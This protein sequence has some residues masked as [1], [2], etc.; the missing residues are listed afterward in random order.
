MPLATIDCTKM[1]H[2][3]PVS[4]YHIRPLHD[5]DSGHARGDDNTY[6]RCGFL[7]AMRLYTDNFHSIRHASLVTR[8]SGC[9]TSLSHTQT[10]TK[11]CPTR[12]LHI[13]QLPRR[14]S[15]S[16]PSSPVHWSVIY[17]IRRVTERNTLAASDDEHTPFC[18]IHSL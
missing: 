10:C 7:L 17:R 4:S 1:S 14:Q 13:S 3:K 6:K 5:L 15:P 12:T 8:S 18:S 11:S 2:A 16:K 9:V